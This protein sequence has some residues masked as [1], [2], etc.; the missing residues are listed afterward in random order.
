LVIRLIKR[1]S[2]SSILFKYLTCRI[3]I[4]A[5][6]P[7]NYRIVFTACSPARLAPLLSMT[8]FSGT[9]L[10]VIVYLKNRRAAARSRRSDNRK[11]RVWPSRSTARYK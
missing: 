1:W 9:P 4:M 7:M 3:S 11:S 8:T 6:V 5:P 2:C 10:L